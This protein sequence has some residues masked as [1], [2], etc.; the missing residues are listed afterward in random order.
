MPTIVPTVAS[1]RAKSK[2]RIKKRLSLGGLVGWWI[3]NHLVH[4]E[5]DYFRKPFL[6][7]PFQW[8]IIEALYALLPDGMRR[9]DDALVGLP[10][11]Q[12]K[13]PLAAAVACAEFAGPVVF[14]G[15]NQDGTPRG[16]ARRSPDIPVAAVS[17]EQADRVFGAARMMIR[18]GAL[19]GLCEIFDTE[20]LFKDASPGR[21]YK[22]P[23]VAGAN[24]GG[25]HSFFVADELHEWVGTKERVHLVLSNNRAKR[26][27]AWQLAITTAGWDMSSLLGKRYA[28]AQRAATDQ[29]CSLRDGVEVAP[30]SLVIWWEASPEWDLEKPAQLEAAIREANPAVRTF[31]PIENVIAQYPKI[32]THEYRRYFLNQFTAAPSQWLPADLWSAALRA[33]PVPDGTPIV[34]GFDGSYNRDSTALIGCTLEHPHLFLVGAWERPEGVKEWTVP[35][36]EVLGAIDAA[37]GKYMVRMLAADDTFGRIWSMDLEALA[38]KGIQVMEWPTRAQ[39]RIAP[40]AAQFYGAIKDQRLTHDG[41][42]ILAAHVGHCVA[43]GTRWGLVPT[44]DAPDS[45]RH[46]DCGI[47]AIVAYDTMVRHTSGSGAW[48]VL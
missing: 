22:V 2:L 16:T 15:W 40:A 9:Y 43:K 36:G 35:R 17:Y 4:G 38:T 34:L 44:K 21:M 25:F 39:S 20:I 3:E 11:G 12:G 29:D 45:P 41:D 31:L 28:A 6:L 46:I 14:D 48:Q 30:R 7:D 19:G 42:P 1:Q 27:G 13:T 37:L 10:K 26:R 24:D 8:P 5:G 23:A 33:E 18:H 32:A 47:A